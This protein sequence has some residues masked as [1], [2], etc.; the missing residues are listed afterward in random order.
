[1]K[2]N[3]ENLPIKRNLKLVYI[4][5]LIIACLFAFTSISG[6][7]LGSTIYPTDE[8]FNN[9]ISND[10]VNLLIGLPII[11]A[12][13]VLTLRGKLIGLLFWPGSLLFVIYNYI[14]YILAMPLNWVVLLYLTLIILSVYIIIKLFSIID[15]KKIQQSLTGVVHER[16]SGAILVALGFLFILQALGAMIDPVMNQIQITE[17][18]LAVHIS[19]FMI[20]P[21]LVVGG[22]LLWRRKALGYVSGLGLLFQASMLFIGLIVFLIIQPLLTKTPFLL[23]DILVVSIMGLIC[24]IPFIFFI[25]GVINRKG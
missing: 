7:L 20:S 21:F 12:S 4:L 5:S 24:F 14:I 25:R 13:I 22:I 8:L 1:M 3:N 10:I 6:I 17:T 11:L 9:F 16:I 19:D 15:G 18:E 2:S 23:V